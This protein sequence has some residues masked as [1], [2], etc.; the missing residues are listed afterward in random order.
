MEKKHF[1]FQTWCSFL[2]TNCLTQRYVIFTYSL[3][4][5]LFADL[6]SIFIFML[7]LI[8]KGEYFHKIKLSFFLSK[9]K[10]TESHIFVFY[11]INYVFPNNHTKPHQNKHKYACWNSFANLS[12][13]D[14]ICKHYFPLVILKLWIKL[15]STEG[16]KCSFL[17]RHARKWGRWGIRWE[18]YNMN[19]N[20][21]SETWE[22]KKSNEKQSGLIVCQLASTNYE[23]YFGNGYSLYNRS[24]WI[25]SSMLFLI[26]NS[27]NVL[28]LAGR[29]TKRDWFSSF[30][31]FSSSKAKFN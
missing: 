2:K 26:L 20:M 29:S 22:N 30:T 31:F 5:L 6:P 10:A 15:L 3:N 4:S 1:C 16:R 21:K 19:R 28:Y 7:L 23:S 14:L 12:S 11:R 25:Q 27:K 8:A 18:I 17:Q 24:N 13:L 9:Q